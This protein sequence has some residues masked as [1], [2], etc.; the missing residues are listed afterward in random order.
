MV[1]FMAFPS[2]TRP[3]NFLKAHCP[4]ICIT[5]DDVKIDL[6]QYHLTLIYLFC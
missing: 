6:S 1:V 4:I 3:A 5:N 2:F